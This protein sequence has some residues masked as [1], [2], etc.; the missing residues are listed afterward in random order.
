MT[1]SRRPEAER[2]W[3]KVDKTEGCWLWTAA[4][5]WDGYGA[6]M[7]GYKKDKNKRMVRAHRYAYEL[8]VGP[9]PEGME[10]DHLCRNRACVNPTHLEPVTHKVN[11]LRGETIS[12]AFA[13]RSHCSKG[14]AYDDQNLYRHPDGSRRCRECHKL[15]ERARRRRAS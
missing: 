15:E 7:T 1:L 10:L 14:H 3:E 12:A 13:A 11:T 4:R 5:Y 6:F 9:I 8:L 2:F